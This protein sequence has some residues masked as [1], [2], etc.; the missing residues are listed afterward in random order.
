MIET[1]RVAIDVSVLRVLVA[2]GRKA[3]DRGRA[4]TNDADAWVSVTRG[5]LSEAL[6]LAEMALDDD[7]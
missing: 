6:R 5:E 7:A 1:T 2:A 4:R 3:L